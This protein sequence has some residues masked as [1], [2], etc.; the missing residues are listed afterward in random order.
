[1][2]LNILIVDDSAVIRKMIIKTL[3]LSD[4]PLGKICEAGDGQQ[5]LEIMDRQWIDLIFADLNM[6]VMNGEVMIERI[7]VNPQWADV[8]IIVVST[9][10]SETRIERLKSQGISFVHKPFSP[11]QIRALVIDILELDHE[12]QTV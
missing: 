2:S 8:P 10:G 6:P 1:M 12:K 4:L 3:R 5:A 9:E 11:E 7:R